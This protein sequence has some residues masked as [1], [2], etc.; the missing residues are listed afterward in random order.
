MTKQWTAPTAT[1]DPVLARLMGDA[2]A[3]DAAQRDVKIAVRNRLEILENQKRNA[4]RNIEALETSD[5]VYKARDTYYTSLSSAY[6]RLARV[7]RQ[8]GELYAQHPDA[9]RY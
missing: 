2:Y 3:K 4:R 9:D 8:L 5:A 1:P 7:S 6:G